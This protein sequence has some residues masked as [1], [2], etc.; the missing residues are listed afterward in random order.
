MKNKS[1]ESSINLLKF[2]LQ[3][4][5]IFFLVCF[6]HCL[7]FINYLSHNMKKQ[8]TKIDVIC[9]IAFSFIIHE[10]QKKKKIIVKNCLHQ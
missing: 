7:R 9:V 3:W 8:I 2:S 5:K 4:F 10:K 6:H 1:F